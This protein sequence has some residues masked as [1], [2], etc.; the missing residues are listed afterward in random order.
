MGSTDNQQ[1]MQGPTNGQTVGKGH[2]YQGRRC[3]T[4]PMLE[5]YIWRIKNGFQA[6]NHICFVYRILLTIAIQFIQLD[7][8]TKAIL[9]NRLKLTAIAIF[10]NLA[11]EVFL[12]SY[13]HYWMQ[14]QQHQEWLSWFDTLTCHLAIDADLDRLWI[15]GLSLQLQDMCCIL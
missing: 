5:V 11:L 6:V 4:V 7:T 9:V 14:N 8:V 2:K 3:R 13:R 12:A 1:G 15:V 10:V